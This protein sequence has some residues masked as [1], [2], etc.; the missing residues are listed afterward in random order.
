[1]NYL[2]S[3][4]NLAKLACGIGFYSLVQALNWLTVRV[5]VRI[6]PAFLVNSFY[7]FFLR[8]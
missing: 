2:K 7:Q 6:A 1:M 4:I 5:L 8:K 3:E